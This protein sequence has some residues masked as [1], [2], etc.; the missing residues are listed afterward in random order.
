[1]HPFFVTLRSGLGCSIQSCIS[2]GWLEWRTCYLTWS[3]SIF[4]QLGKI[5]IKLQVNPRL[6]CKFCS[7]LLVLFE[8]ELVFVIFDSKPITNQNDFFTFKCHK[9]D[10]I[11]LLITTKTLFYWTNAEKNGFS[12]SFFIGKL[13]NS[14]TLLL[15]QSRRR[16]KIWQKLTITFSMIFT[17]KDRF[18]ALF[19]VCRHT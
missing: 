7:M 8:G 11:C 5:L 6:I 17:A 12:T 2:E 1:M 4:A 3:L 13:L 15:W 16:A 14:H 10:V 18:H 19:K 9:N